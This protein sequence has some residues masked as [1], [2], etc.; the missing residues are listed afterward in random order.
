MF[1]YLVAN[2]L[3][4]NPDYIMSYDI[5]EEFVFLTNSCHFC[6]IGFHNNKTHFWVDCVQFWYQN[7]WVQYTFNGQY[8][9]LWLD[10]PCLVLQQCERTPEDSH[11]LLMFNLVLYFLVV[12]Q[13]KWPFPWP[14]RPQVTSHGWQ[15][16]TSHSQRGGPPR[17][18]LYLA[19]YHLLPHKRVNRSQRNR[20][21]HRM[22]LRLM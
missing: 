15:V 6:G 21:C 5:W 7:Y 16:A 18:C 10:S 8:R 19:C 3:Y 20:C 4:V 22:V 9:V 14:A 12:S 17:D 2:F 1:L 11:M 13:I